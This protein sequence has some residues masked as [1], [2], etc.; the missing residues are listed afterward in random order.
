MVML[1]LFFNL[2]RIPKPEFWVNAAAWGVVYH[3]DCLDDT[4]HKAE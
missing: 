2:L 1:G 3:R 4:K